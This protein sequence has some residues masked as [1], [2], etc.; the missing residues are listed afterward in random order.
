MHFL[1][2]SSCEAPQCG[3][4][5]LTVLTLGHRTE[6]AVFSELRQMHFLPPSTVYLDELQNTCCIVSR[7]GVL[8]FPGNRLLDYILM[9]L[10]PCI[11]ARCKLHM[12][13]TIFKNWKVDK[14]WGKHRTRRETQQRKIET[15]QVLRLRQQLII[16]PELRISLRTRDTKMLA[17][18][19]TT[20]WTEES[21]EQKKKEADEQRKQER[22]QIGKKF[23]D[24]NSPDH[25]WK[26]GTWDAHASPAFIWD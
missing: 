7:S 12:Y 11:D 20:R 21:A 18:S 25:I 22:K 15:N 13:M 24:E 6:D 19:R 26:N 17:R 8:D 14:S 4:E 5:K 1:V 2:H 9:M 10:F 3:R 23:L 16:L